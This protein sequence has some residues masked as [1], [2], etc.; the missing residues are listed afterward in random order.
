MRGAGPLPVVF[1][2]QDQIAVLFRRL[3][4]NTL[5]FTQPDPLRVSVT[6]EEARPGQWAVSVPA[7]G[8]GIEPRQGARIFEAFQRG[9]SSERYA[10]A[11]LSYSPPHPAGL[12]GVPVGTASAIQ[13]EA[14][15]S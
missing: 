8:V 13:L 2:D 14:S 12:S 15:A 7:S 1:G 11:G 5:K 4:E 6:V 9:H 10:G 3:L